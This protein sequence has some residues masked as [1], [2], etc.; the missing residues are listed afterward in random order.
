M[1]RVLTLLDEAQKLLKKKTYTEEEDRM[2][3]L[4]QSEAQK[5]LNIPV[6]VEPPSDTIPMPR[7]LPSEGS[8]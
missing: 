3:V 7:N 5:E 4:L 6:L 2:V 1:S 8:M